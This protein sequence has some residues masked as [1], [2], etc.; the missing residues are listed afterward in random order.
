[1]NLKQGTRVEYNVQTL[2]GKGTVVGVSVVEQPI[3]GQCYIIEPDESIRNEVYD[4]THFV[5]WE[6]QLKVIN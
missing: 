6:F 3:V 1:M 4:Y 5:A 2:K